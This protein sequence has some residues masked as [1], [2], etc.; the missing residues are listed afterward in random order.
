MKG[1][2]VNRKAFRPHWTFQEKI[3]K[4][5]KNPYQTR[6]GTEPARS[7][8]ERLVWKDR[9]AAAWPPKDVDEG[10]SIEGTILRIEENVNATAE[11]KLFDYVLDVKGEELRVWGSKMLNLQLGKNDIGKQVRIKY[12]GTGK[13]QKG[14]NA[15]KLF[16]V[17]VNEK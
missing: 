7:G 14:K 11:N 17:Q 5:V 16:K 8:G 1:V 6:F 13:A 10:N 12:L 9:T 3:E 2:R 4:A 15:P